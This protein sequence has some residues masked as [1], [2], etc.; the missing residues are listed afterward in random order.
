MTMV[1]LKTGEI[2][3]NILNSIFRCCITV[4][5]GSDMN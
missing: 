1:T 3:N 2:Q 4:S 5:Y